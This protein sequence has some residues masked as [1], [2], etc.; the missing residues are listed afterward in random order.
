MQKIG[1]FVRSKVPVFVR[2]NNLNEE[3]ILMGS[4]SINYSTQINRDQSFNNNDDYQNEND[5]SF[6]IDHVDNDTFS[7][8][9]KINHNQINEW[10]AAWN[11]TNAIQVY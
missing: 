2:N 9:E 1:V 10:Q 3:S 6:Q 11:V 5:Q 7:F 8:N 4:S